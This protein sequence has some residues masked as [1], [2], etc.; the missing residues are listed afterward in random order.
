MGDS[1]RAELGLDPSHLLRSGTRRG[2]VEVLLTGVEKP[3]RLEVTRR[4]FSS[5]EP[6]PKV[7][8]LGYGATRLLPRPGMPSK[9]LTEDFARVENM[10]DP[11]SPLRDATSWLLELPPKTFDPVARALKGIL[12][13]EEGAHLRRNRRAGRIEVDSYGD[14][15]PLE[16]LS[17]GYQSVLGLAVDIMSVM[18]HR[19]EA[20]EVA[21]GIVT[22][23]ELGA[24]IHP[25]WR[26]RIVPALRD[27]F[28]RVQ[29]LAS[30]HDPLCLRGL[31]DGEVVLLRRTPEGAVHRVA[32]LPSIEGVRV[33]QLL[34][35]E[36]FG[37]NSTIDPELDRQFTR[38][39]QLKGKWKPTAGDRTELEELSSALEGRQVLG[40]TRRERL[41]LEAADDYLAAETRVVEDGE[42]DRLKDETKRKLADLW[43][44][45]E[46][47][48]RRRCEAGRPRGCAGGARRHRLGRRPG[49]LACRGLLR[50]RRER[51]A[52][53]S[54]SRPTSTTT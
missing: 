47:L 39:Y 38:Y 21:E 2:S 23:D 28:P 45:T 12:M 22:I 52:S 50:G 31:S 48:G 16:Y 7:L 51:R 53:R 43:A 40:R 32:D 17:D 19:W 9:P 46:P 42:R 20:M 33:D 36:F 11:F 37:L 13:F 18:L 30:T 35:S 10:F 15:V 29:F 3:I 27:V 5:S 14:R 26:M 44:E 54:A 6:D 34:T 49:A 4:G 25:R 8:L 41:L 1:R 24:H